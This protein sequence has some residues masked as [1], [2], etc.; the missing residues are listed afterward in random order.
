M[1]KLVMY[2][3]IAGAAVGAVALTPLM[4]NAATSRYQGNQE[5]TQAIRA[6]DGSGARDQ[7]A[8]H[9]ESQDRQYLHIA[10]GTCD[11]TGDGSG[12]GSQQRQH[13]R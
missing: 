12:T 13:G 9:T 11:G 3:I 1:N 7:I 6:R 2:A 5:N 10:D 4:A 8:L